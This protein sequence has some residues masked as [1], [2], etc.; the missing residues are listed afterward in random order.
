M[1]RTGRGGIHLLVGTREDHGRALVLDRTR[2]GE[3]KGRGGFIVACPSRTTGAY[4]WLRSP[5]EVDLA[6]APAW[7]WTLIAT[8]NT[9]AH[10]AQGPLDMRHGEARLAGLARAVRDAREGS[11][12]NLLYWATRR[13]LEDGIPSPVATSVLARMAIVAGLDHVEVGRTVASAVEAAAR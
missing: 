6:E 5:L 10:E 13:A 11:R 7:L 1:A 9:V 8:T 12:N 3:L 2:I 4:T